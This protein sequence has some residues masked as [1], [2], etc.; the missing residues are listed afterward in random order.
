MSSNTP[1]SYEE[2]KLKAEVREVL[3]QHDRLVDQ[4]IDEELDAIEVDP[5]PLEEA[6]KIAEKAMGITRET[7]SK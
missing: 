4:A 6:K 2:N 1:D 5:L 7:E 3:L